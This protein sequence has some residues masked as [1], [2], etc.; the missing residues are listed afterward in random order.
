MKQ[1]YDLVNLIRETGDQLENRTGIDSIMIPG[2][3]MYFRMIEGFPMLGGRFT[4]FKSMI[5]ELCAFYRACTNA[6]DFRAL[7]SKV[8]DKNANDPGL[9]DSN[10]WLRNAFRFEE[11]ELGPIYGDM[12]RN[13]PGYK[14]IPQWDAAGLK[15]EYREIIKRQHEQVKKDGWILI[16]TTGNPIERIDEGLPSDFSESAIYYKPIDQ[17]GDAIRT[18]I[19]NPSSRRIL[20]HAWNP[21]V[22]DEISLPACHLLYQLL[23]NPKTKKMHMCVY[24]RSND[25]G[26]GAPYNISQAAAQLHFL[27]HLTGYT[28][29]M[30]SYFTGDAH[31]YVNQLEWLDEQLELWNADQRYP[32][33][34]LKI[35]DRVPT[36]DQLVIRVG[37]D[38]AAEEAVNWLKWVEP[39]DFKLEGYQ[40]HTLKTPTPPMAV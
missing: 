2:A 4:P 34:S 26:L 12:W 5:G 30:L 38:K 25:V 11:D 39:G 15:E 28:P 33:P 18:V 1:Y 13:W 3:A 21:A 36:Y 32:L 27:S 29:G 23:P 40:Y 7:G 20:F 31:V 35:S 19:N 24:L 14:I 17:L 6:G 22:L 9:N 10:A 37:K 16:G 8:W